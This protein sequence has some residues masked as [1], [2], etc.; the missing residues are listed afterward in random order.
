GS[1]PPFG[2]TTTLEF[3]C[4]THGAPSIRGLVGGNIESLTLNGQKLDPPEDYSDN[5]L[6]QS[7]LS[8]ENVLPVT[9]SLRH[10]RNG[11]GLHRFAVPAEDRVY[12]YAHFE[13]RD[14]RRLFATFEQPDLKPSFTFDVAAPSGW[15]VMSNSPTPEPE[16]VRD[17]V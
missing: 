1:E 16:T 9:A 10:S 12:L 4:T 7:G 8:E 6:Q 15:Q 5:R 3:G 13:V 11:V 17:G 2:S 14:A